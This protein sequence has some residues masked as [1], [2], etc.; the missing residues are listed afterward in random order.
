MRCSARRPEDSSTAAR[1]AYNLWWTPAII[2]M[3]ESS[4]IV[5][6]YALSYLVILFDR[7][8]CAAKFD[9]DR[10]PAHHF[11]QLVGINRC[12]AIGSDIIDS[13]SITTFEPVACV[14]FLVNETRSSFLW[15][16]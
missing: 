15:S 9:V 2:E 7:R 10:R 12:S 11:Q 5:G 1:V 4:T 6:F 16:L 8:P 13:Q 14:L 3:P